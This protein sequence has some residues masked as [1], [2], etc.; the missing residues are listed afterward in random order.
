MCFYLNARLIISFISIAAF[1]KSVALLPS[2]T[3]RFWKTEDL[4]D[5]RFCAREK[6]T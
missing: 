5:E 2:D 1:S 3:G 4:C 6:A